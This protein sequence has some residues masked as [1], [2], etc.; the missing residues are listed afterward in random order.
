MN[1]KQWLLLGIILTN[2]LIYHILTAETSKPF[3]SGCL[4]YCS[5]LN[6][7]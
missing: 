6:T 1:G 3:S 2:E 5:Y 4:C 7:C